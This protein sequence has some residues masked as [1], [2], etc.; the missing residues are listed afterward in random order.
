LALR[1]VALVLAGLATGL[2][3]AAARELVRTSAPSSPSTHLSGLDPSAAAVLEQASLDQDGRPV[4]PYSI[5]PGGV[6]GAEELKRIVADD[7]IVAAHYAHMS[8]ADARLGR[9]GAPRQVYMSYRVG[10]QVY[11]TRQ[12]VTLPQGE[13]V[14]T[15]GRSLIRARCGNCISDTP[16]GPTSDAEPD[17]AEFDRA[18]APAS[19]RLPDVTGTPEPALAAG[20]SLPPVSPL[21]QS[22]TS[23]LAPPGAPFA[24]LGPDGFGP[25]SGVPAPGLTIPRG[26]APGGDPGGE[27]SPPVTA[28]TPAGALTPENGGLVPPLGPVVPPGWTSAPPQA[29]Q[30]LVEPPGGNPES[31][32]EPAIPEPGL[33]L[34]VGTGLGIYSLRRLRRS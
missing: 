32:R 5:V 15:D 4:Y 9:T 13:A 11:W 2:M 17:A 29:G 16:Q 6:F 27:N 21:A 28:L 1:L 34:L 10:D 14:L 20:A 24:S 12:K 7:P 33:L 8:V 22:S 23:G 18:L 30:T 3:V 31:P 19:A 25:S 26:F